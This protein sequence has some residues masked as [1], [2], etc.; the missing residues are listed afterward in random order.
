M[1]LQWPLFNANGHFW[2]MQKEN[3][4]LQPPCKQKFWGVPNL[5]HMCVILFLRKTDFFNVYNSK[6]RKQRNSIGLLTNIKIIFLIWNS[7]YKHTIKK[8]HYWNKHGNVK[9]NVFCT[10]SGKHL[11]WVFLRHWVKKWKFFNFLLWHQN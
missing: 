6:W 10:S 9:E 2:E 5:L 4:L 1:V 11:L 7:K 3:Q 8:F